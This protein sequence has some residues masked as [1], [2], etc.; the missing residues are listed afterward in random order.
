MKTLTSTLLGVAVAAVNISHAQTILTNSLDTAFQPPA[1]A[2]T[3]MVALPDGKYLVAG[4]FQFLGGTSLNRVARL[5]ADGSVDQS[6][7]S[8]EANGSVKVKALA[9]QWDRRL[10]VCGDFKE[11]R[12]A[13][14]HRIVRLMPNGALDESFVPPMDPTDYLGSGIDA[15]AVDHEQHTVYI[16]GNFNTSGTTYR[17]F[18]VV[19]LKADGS[20]DENFQPHPTSELPGRVTALAVDDQ[21]RV[22][23][24]GQFVR[25]FTTLPGVR[26]FLPDGSL[27]GSFK[28]VVMDQEVTRIVLQPD[29]K[30]DVGGAFTQVNQQPRTAVARLHPDGSLDYSFKTTSDL[31]NQGHRPIVKDLAL[32]S[33]GCLIVGGYVAAP[34][35]WD[36]L[37][38][39]LRADGSRDP[40]FIDPLMADTRSEDVVEA[41]A[42]DGNGSLAFGGRFKLSGQTTAGGCS[43]VFAASAPAAP[44]I[45]VS[46][47][48]VQV[49]L[50]VHPGSRLTLE[51][52][53][54]LALAWRAVTSTN[55]VASG[56]WTVRQ[57]ADSAATGFYRVR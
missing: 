42:L 55:P 37:L 46:A 5:N 54:D 13:T 20:L 53:S 39:R 34:G 16:G 23:V 33:D 44:L 30:I 50:Q 19:R 8:G 18:M 36:P 28:R 40:E 1:Q 31:G 3:S 4:D 49:R 27:D 45:K 22:L 15:V 11:F 47:D 6:F 29:G 14:R 24:G 21:G 38:L 35:T 41:L 9:V 2:F 17:R 51:T 48:Q 26:R 7:D 56:V 52:T 57:P 32:Q 10:L 12:G 43:R 25:D